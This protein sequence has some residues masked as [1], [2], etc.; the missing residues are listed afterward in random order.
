MAVS[1]SVLVFNNGVERTMSKFLPAMNITV[2]DKMPGMWR[3]I[4][5][6]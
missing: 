1:L 2:N 4:D 5:A 3:E 6:D